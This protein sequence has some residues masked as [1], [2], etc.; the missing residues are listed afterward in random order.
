MV[1]GRQDSVNAADRP[2]K[3]PLASN[4]AIGVGGKLKIEKCAPILLAAG[5]AIPFARL[6][7]DPYDLTPRA[8][9]PAFWKW[10]A[11]FG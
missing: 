6:G 3:N 8:R 7:N 5:S 10:Q 4:H 11:L 9:T 2:S 1:A